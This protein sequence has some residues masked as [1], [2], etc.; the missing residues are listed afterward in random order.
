MLGRAKTEPAKDAGSVDTG[1][2]SARPRT[3]AGDDL[4]PAR[5]DRIFVG[6]HY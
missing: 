2:V 1:Q 4:Q 5:A 3:L 6:D